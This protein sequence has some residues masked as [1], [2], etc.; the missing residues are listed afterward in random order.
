MRK[1]LFLFSLFAISL[2]MGPAH[3]QPGVTE[4]YLVLYENAD[5]TPPKLTVRP[6]QDIYTLRD[7]ASDGGKKYHRGFDNKVSSVKY[8]I[9]PGW[10]VVLYQNTKYREWPYELKGKGQVANLGE[11]NDR[12]SSVRWIRIGDN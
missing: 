7:R 10:K 12:A 1:I 8:S 9:P 5:F 11:F 3:A 2:A 4:Y 6:H